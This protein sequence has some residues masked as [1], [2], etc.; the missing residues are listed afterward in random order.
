MT[1]PDEAIEFTGARRVV[2]ASASLCALGIVALVAGALFDPRRALVSYL[3]A[4]NYVVTIALGALIFLMICH[5]M[6]AEWPTLLRRLTEAVVA[7]IPL[8]VLL[9]IPIL[10]GL[11]VLYPWIRPESLH[12]ERTRN[13]V[14]LKA[15]YLNLNWFVGRTAFYFAS[16]IFV[17]FWLRRWSR[18][19][20]RGP[21]PEAADRMYALSGAL[22]P[23]VALT[24]SF[25][26]FDWVM[27]LAPTWASTMFPV[28]Y[29]AGG[30]VAALA[31]LTVLTWAADRTGLIHGI[32]PSHYYA[33]GRLLLSFVIFWAYVE[34]FQFMLIWIANKPEEVTFYLARIQGGWAIESAIL[35]LAQFVL[36][37]F[38]LLDYRM[39]RKRDQIAAVA[40]WLLVAHYIDVHWLI[41]PMGGAVG[42]PLHWMDIAALV[43]VVGAS[44]LF[45]ALRLRG[46]RMVPVHDPALAK[47][48]RYESV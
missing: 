28:C 6:H 4:F 8:Y 38:V 46:V 29:F 27:S 31:L 40:A 9:F 35:V 43:A 34:F 18:A 30:F 24:L 42:R 17:A 10:A 19:M 16:W 3:T 36:P 44:V 33:L 21:A 2:Q 5:A 37:F 41:V 32:N 11:R 7:T 23:L 20:D 39:K 22:L 26:A 1:E 45:G 12:D 13:L 25:A 48:L 14:A 15:P 47:A